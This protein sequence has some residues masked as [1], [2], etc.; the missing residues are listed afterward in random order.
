MVITFK[1]MRPS[2]IRTEPPTEASRWM[3]G[4]D[5]DTT[6]WLPTTSRLVRAISSPAL[7]STTPV[8]SSPV[9]YLGPGTSTMMPTGSPSR[10]A[11]STHRTYR[12]R[13]RIEGAV[14]E[15]QSGDAH[16]GSDQS[17][18]LLRAFSR[19]AQ[20]ADYLRLGPSPSHL[21]PRS[22]RQLPSLPVSLILHDSVYR[23]TLGGR[24]AIELWRF[25]QS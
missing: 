22:S 3:P 24:R 6:S 20:R 21:Y 18:D 9:R 13:V 10:S 19:R 11:S 7:S 8:D 2:S 1:A 4:G 12:K 15:V 23:G 25:R 5:T 16:P 14:R 17:P